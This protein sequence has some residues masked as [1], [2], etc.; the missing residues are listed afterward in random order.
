MLDINS[1]SSER[2]LFAR[3]GE[4]VS[5]AAFEAGIVPR[6]TQQAFGHD[7]SS[8]G[9]SSKAQLS[10]LIQRRGVAAVVATMGRKPEPLRHVERKLH[11]VKGRLMPLETEENPALREPA[12]REPAARERAAIV[13]PNVSPS[14]PRRKTA[15]APKPQAPAT[16]APAPK[17][18]KLQAPALDAHKRHQFTVRLRDHDFRL[19]ME[20]AVRSGR[21]YQDIIESAVRDYVIGDA[22]KMEEDSS[23][24]DGLISRF[25]S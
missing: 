18:P 16:K 1:E 21:T 12:A 23:E 9:G 25:F 6:E 2:R 10:T 3:K 22:L 14:R 24:P 7:D 20:M 17:A 13:L 5:T 11:E 4:A 8:R 19:F 15:E